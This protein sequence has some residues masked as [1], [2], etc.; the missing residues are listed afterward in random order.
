MVEDPHP[1]AYEPL[2]LNEDADGAPATPGNEPKATT[3]SLRRTNRL[4]F[5]TAGW[6]ANFRGLLCYLCIA[7]C[8]SIVTGIFTAIPFVPSVVGVL[9]AGLALVQLTTAWVHI[10]VSVPSSL[11]FWK[12]LPPF[13]RTFE[14]TC[15]PVFVNWAASSALGLIVWLTAAGLKLP[16]WDYKRPN[17][18]PVGDSSMIWKDIVVILVFVAFTALVVVPT[19]VVLIR[20]Q[21]SL[22]P[23]D[24]DTIVPLDR[25]F[26][27]VVEPLIVGGKGYASWMA[28]F[29]TFPRSSWIRLYIL[30]AKIALVTIAFYGLVIAVIIPEVLLMSN[31]TKPN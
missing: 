19:Q 20:V 11:P 24:A 29:N 23:P 25:S 1:P 18:V 16:V 5:S 26:G 15:V 17:E 30:Y 8:T 2:A 13:R 10:V 9:L 28:A 14:A 4:L 31:K 7:L 22:L 6:R 27:G 21:A 12:R 3:S